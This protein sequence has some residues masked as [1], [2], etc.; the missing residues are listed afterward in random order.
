MP[1]IDVDLNMINWACD[2]HEQN[3]QTKILQETWKNSLA[4]F[5]V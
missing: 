2:R 3:V 1:R 5:F 4:R